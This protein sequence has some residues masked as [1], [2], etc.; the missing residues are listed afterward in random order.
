MDG[1]FCVT[2]FALLSG[3]NEAQSVNGIKVTSH[4]VHAV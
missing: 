3:A 1:K 4:E 2:A